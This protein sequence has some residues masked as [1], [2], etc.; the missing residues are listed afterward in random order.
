MPT[1]D[2]LIVIP[3]HNALA[4]VFACLRS[5][6]QHVQQTADLL[7]VDNG[8]NLETTTAIKEAF[9]NVEILRQAN[10]G[11]GAAANLG[12]TES[13]KRNYRYTWVLNS[14]TVVRENTGEVLWQFMEQPENAQVGSCSPIIRREESN[15]IDFAGGWLRRSNWSVEHIGD[16]NVGAQALAMKPLETFLTGCSLFIRNE[17]AKDVGMFDERF[18]MYSEDCDFS[19]R[20]VS[21]GWELRLVPSANIVHTVHGSTGG[22]P[23]RNP[24]STYYEVRNCFLLWRQY[25]HGF[26][27][28]TLTLYRMLQ[29]I[30]QLFINRR[31]SVS[32]EFK[33]AAAEGV[34]D[35]LRGRFGKKRNSLTAIQAQIVSTLL[36][37]LVLPLRLASKLFPNDN[38]DSRG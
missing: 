36:W 34:V 7:V 26:L 38:C 22:K 29:W 12:I 20:L 30:V 24:F 23:D 37:Y 18:F 28:R 13:G 3:V 35:G 9:P 14:D 4:H 17:A 1:R 11:Y 6:E 25:T 8:S 2:V 16:P 31:F 21:K 15:D 33:Q 5:L 32:G 27:N 10:L 19:V